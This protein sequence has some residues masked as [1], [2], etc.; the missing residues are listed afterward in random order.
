MSPGAVAL[1]FGGLA[2]AGTGL[3]IATRHV[4]TPRERLIDAGL[5]PVEAIAGATST[6]ISIA[7]YVP[8]LIVLLL[9]GLLALIV[10]V[11]APALPGIA[12]NVAKGYSK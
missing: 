6:A 3:Y 10:L 5:Q 8:I 2:L 9:F 7:P 12:G 11:I 4:P 1:G